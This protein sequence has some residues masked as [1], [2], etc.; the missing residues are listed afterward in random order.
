MNN[1]EDM[2]NLSNASNIPARGLNNQSLSRG[3]SNPGLSSPPPGLNRGLHIPP[4]GLDEREERDEYRNQDRGLHIPQTDNMQ[5]GGLGLGLSNGLENLRSADDKD[6]RSSQDRPYSDK[7]EVEVIKEANPLSDIDM[8]DYVRKS[9]SHINESASE[10]EENSISQEEFLQ[11]PSIEEAEDDDNTD[12]SQPPKDTIQDIEPPSEDEQEEYT[13]DMDNQTEKKHISWPNRLGMMAA[14]VVLFVGGVFTI[15]HIKA[16][17][18]ADPDN[19]REGTTHALNVIRGGEKV[20]D[21]GTS[22]FGVRNYGEFMEDVSNYD[23]DEETNPTNE[24]IEKGKE[25]INKAT[26]Q[27][28]EDTTELVVDEK[29]QGEDSVMDKSEEY[30]QEDI[31]VKYASNINIPNTA[32]FTTIYFND[33]FIE[34]IPALSADMKYTVLDSVEGYIQVDCTDYVEENL[35]GTNTEFIY[36][37]PKKMRDKLNIDGG[38]ISG[39]IYISSQTQGVVSFKPTE[40]K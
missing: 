8:K 7:D 27:D 20:G 13:S 30:E 34:T 5:Y 35:E 38:N 21:D 4:R 18:D 24:L 23:I 29:D 10:Q 3:L 26:N 33:T 17:L 14:C 11:S 28:T 32:E 1:R 40:I 37:L 16:K 22:V 25:L 36:K 39:D 19:M 2:D 12:K 31:R 15:K 6:F 9:T